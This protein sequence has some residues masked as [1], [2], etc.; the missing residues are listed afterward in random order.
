MNPRPR[1]AKISFLER[2]WCRFL[3]AFVLIS[4][5]HLPLYFLEL[6]VQTSPPPPDH[7][8]FL[9]VVNLSLAA[10]SPA[11]GKTVLFLNELERWARIADP[12][13]SVLPNLR[14]GFSKYAFPP[15]EYPP[16]DLPQWTLPFE[17]WPKHDAPGRDPD[18]R[19][20]P[21][22]ELIWQ[23]WNRHTSIVLPPKPAMVS[24]VGA[25]WTVVGLGPLRE[26]PKL[27]PENWY[28]DPVYQA[29]Q[30]L[31]QR[32]TI[33]E[34]GVLPH[35]E[36]QWQSPAPRPLPRVQVRQ[37]SGS[38]KLD[39]LAMQAVQAF[40]QQQRRE[41]PIASRKADAGQNWLLKI[42]WR[43]PPAQ[44]VP[45]AAGKQGSPGKPE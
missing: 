26:T 23:E 8:E 2:G 18:I 39:A 12:R 7:R 19:G 43:F 13:L 14:T 10:P 45:E 3:L 37:S 5:L 24:P 34:V 35:P 16:P 4:L 22:A 36:G 44:A 41:N 6:P 30:A 21:L 17:F 32:S 1:S 42:D 9:P 11:A 29:E 31:L 33:L 25:F 27:Q 38:R 20:L 28:E 15:T 40:I